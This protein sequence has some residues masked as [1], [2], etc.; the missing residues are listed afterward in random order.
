MDLQYVVYYTRHI[1]SVRLCRCH[2]SAIQSAQSELIT[3]RLLQLFCRRGPGSVVKVISVAST[4]TSPIT[5]QIISLAMTRPKELLICHL[6]VD[7]T[8]IAAM[9]NETVV[10]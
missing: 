4:M 8:I 5:K 9:R 2:H 7:A 10:L 3:D 1:A 6:L